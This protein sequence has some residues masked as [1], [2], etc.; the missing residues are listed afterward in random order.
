MALHDKK[1]KSKNYYLLP[2]EDDLMRTCKSKNFIGKVMFLVAL[3]QSRL[4]HKEM[5]FSLKKLVYFLLLCKSQPKGIVL[6]EL[7]VH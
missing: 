4:M 2:D 5:N 6:T 1:K 7:Q 3:A